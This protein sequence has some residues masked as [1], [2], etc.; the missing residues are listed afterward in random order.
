MSAWVMDKRDIDVL[1][2]ALVEFD[3][4]MSLNGKDYAYAKNLDADAIGKTLWLENVRSVTH[5]YNLDT[6]PSRDRQDEHAEYVDMVVGYKWTP[7]TGIKPGPVAKL[8]SCYDYQS[9]EHDEWEASI[10]KDIIV[11]LND[12]LVTFL[13]G[14][15][16]GP[17]GINNAAD[18]TKVVTSKMKRRA[19]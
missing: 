7:Y 11:R 4:W 9:C 5:R 17:W 18:L 6:S 16:D 19:A 8:A 13:P 14:Y 12:K 2:S 1:V 3:V 15:E 10:A